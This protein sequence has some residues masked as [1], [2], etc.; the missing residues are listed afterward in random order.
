MRVKM[1]E[2]CPAAS[3]IGV[4]YSSISGPNALPFKVYN[5]VPPPGIAAQ[6]AF[7][8]IGTSDLFGFGCA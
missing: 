6:F 5:M 2:G 1:Q 3:Q 4:D 8:F 7:K